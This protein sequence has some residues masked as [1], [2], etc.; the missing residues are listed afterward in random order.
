M[1][2][3]LPLV[4]RYG[5]QAITA[6]TTAYHIGKKYVPSIVHG[7]K[8]LANNLF[9]SGK[10]KS[11]MDY[12]KGLAKPKGLAKLI[13]K[14]IPGVAKSASNL[15]SSGKLMKGVSNVASDANSLIGASKGLLGDKYSSKA[16]ALVN[17]GVSQASHFHDIASKYNEQ[18]K[19]LA[20]QFTSQMNS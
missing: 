8:T 14:D 11:A 10:R 18:G 4:A 1:A 3:V 15:I 7:V 5:P 13:T 6:A 20:N 9:S 19:H 12:V 17:K 2:Q 16:T